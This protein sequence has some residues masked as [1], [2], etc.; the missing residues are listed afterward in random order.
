MNF[1]NDY[2]LLDGEMK[3]PEYLDMIKTLEE[4]ADGWDPES[5]YPV[6][7]AEMEE[8]RYTDTRGGTVDPGAPRLENRASLEGIADLADPE[9]DVG[10]PFVDLVN[11]SVEKDDDGLIVRMRLADLSGPLTFNQPRV[12]DNAM[13]YRWA[14]VFDI[15]GDG[16]DEYSV[17]WMRF[18]DPVAETIKGGIVDNAQMSVWRLSGGGAEQEEADVRGEQ[19]GDELILEVLPCGFVSSIRP[20]TRIHFR[21][22]YSDGKSE[23]EDLMP[24]QGEAP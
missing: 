20:E 19:K 24:D 4:Q 17:E 1:M 6:I 8:G 21:T 5:V 15:D 10:H 11:A 13:E 14:A 23:D 16:E 3:K 2:E 22:Y 12:P 7:E 9:D 18:K